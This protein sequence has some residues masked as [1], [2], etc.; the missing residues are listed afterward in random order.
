MIATFISATVGI[1]ASNYIYQWFCASPDWAT[2]TERSWF[3][4]VALVGVGAA[5]SINA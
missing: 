5:L 2:A 1:V 4:L 3:Q